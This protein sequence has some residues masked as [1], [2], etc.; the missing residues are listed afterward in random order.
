MTRLARTLGSCSTGIG[1]LLLWAGQLH[2]AS[3]QLRER[4]NDDRTFQISVR[5]TAEGKLKTPVQETKAAELPLE[6]QARMR[7]RER[8]LASAG[9]EDRAWR[10]L[11]IYEQA[12]S[13]IVV[14]EQTT[15][16][17]LEPG[18]EVVVEGRRS[19]LWHYAREVPLQR[20]DVDLLNL[21]G[22]PLTVM[23]TLPG[24][25]MEVG[26]EW[27]VPDWAAQMFVGVEAATKTKL[28]GKL[29]S[30]EE[31]IATLQLIGEVAG[32]TTG[33]ATKVTLNA[34][35]TFDLGQQC[36]TSL[37]LIQR[38]DRGISTVSPGM[39]VAATVQWERSPT[40]KP[41]P[42][43]AL[44]EISLDPPPLARLL[45]FRSKFWN[46]S[47]LH[48]RDWH[49]FQ[50]IPEVAV[51]RLVDSGS[52]ISQCNIARIPKMKPGEHV[53]PERFERDIRTSLG[54]QLSQIVE[55]EQVPT[56]DGRF[57]YRVV[58]AGEANGLAMVWI[59][60][61]CAH[62]DGRQISFVFALEHSNLETL[63]S[64]DFSIVE[65]LE[66]EPTP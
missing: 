16:L 33:A 34:T 62:P 28:T 53:P 46:V 8:R 3:Y 9:R 25:E 35:A 18:R 45:L 20:R 2:A 29:L 54:E 38:E 5:V 50:E 42:D 43:S 32:A 31:Q 11:R 55:S 24:G 48:D 10:S 21:P 61:L 51:F 23:A 66:F 17:Q 63:D 37:K 30:V 19:G 41:L 57:L 27:N 47:L 7:Y 14:K 60:Y 15:Q 49:L 12:T 26:D 13:R 22:D 6:M 36:L 1:L 65:S 39:E 52:L 40:A 64:Q 58:A 44:Q 56:E 4:P 59:Y